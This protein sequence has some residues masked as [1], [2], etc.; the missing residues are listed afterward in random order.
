MA[1]AILISNQNKNRLTMQYN[2]EP[3]ELDQVVGLYLVAG[4]NSPK[5]DGYLTKGQLLEHF[6]PG[7]MLENDYLEVDMRP[8]PEVVAP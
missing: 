6:I 7:R 4:F 2:M 1:K 5:P 3:D 8:A